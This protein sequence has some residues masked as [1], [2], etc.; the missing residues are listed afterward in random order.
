MGVLEEPVLADAPVWEPST[1]SQISEAEP[2]GDSLSRECKLTIISYCDQIRQAAK[3]Q[4]RARACAALCK[5]HVLVP[6]GVCKAK[7]SC[8][9]KRTC[10]KRHSSHAA[11][12]QR[13]VCGAAPR[14]QLTVQSHCEAP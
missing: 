7:V 1:V 11:G 9:T 6:R 5:L 10:T 8:R 2:A 14:A 13:G 12:G 4:D 3:D